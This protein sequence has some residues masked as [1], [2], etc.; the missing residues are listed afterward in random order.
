MTRIAIITSH[1]IQYYAPLF[2]LLSEHKKIEIKV[3]YTWSQASKSKFDR[4]FGREV[5]W[6]IPLLEGY[7]YEFIENVSP[8][9]GVYWFFGLINP[10]LIKK[11][12]SFQPDAIL[13]NGWNYWSHL[14]VMRHFKGKI[15]VYFR[16]DSTLLD[17]TSKLKKRIRNAVLKWVYSFADKAFYVGSNNKA[18]F[19][20]AGFKDED[21]V[22]A[23]HTVNNDFFNEEDIKFEAHALDWRK[24]LGIKP[25]DFVCLFAGKFEPKKNPALLI[26]AFIKLAQQINESTNQH[27]HLLI[28]GNGILE[29]ELRR[30]GKDKPFIHFLPFQNQSLMPVIYRI[31]DVYC[32]PS[33]GPGETWGLG[34]NESMACGRPVIV[35]DKVGCALDLIKPG[36]NG[37]IFDH[38]SEDALQNCLSFAFQNRHVFRKNKLLIQDFIKSWSVEECAK[39]IENEF[40]PH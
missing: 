37:Y 20:A 25:D 35:S 15:P 12:E 30:L 7:H 33:K 11:I 28:V 38:I 21:L 16:G 29:E 1:P 18:Y 10:S 27:V 31:S 6:D 2:R 23:P 13:L 40:Q 3:F 26:N 9:P 39:K 32:L 22:F 14:R 8:K 4:D 19:L 24:E 34:V 36:E 17:Q 5:E